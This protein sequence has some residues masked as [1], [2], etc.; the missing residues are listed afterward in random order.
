MRKAS[1][2]AVS[3]ASESQEERQ[4]SATIAI[5]AS[6]IRQIFQPRTSKSSHLW[7]LAQK[8]HALAVTV[9]EGWEGLPP[10][11]REL[12]TTFACAVIDPPKG[13]KGFFRTFINRF[14]SA[15]VLAWIVL[16]GEQDAFIAYATAFQRLVNAIL[17]AIEREGTGYQKALSEALEGAF[18]DWE[19]SEAMTAEEACE[20]LRQISD[21]A[22]REL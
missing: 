6:E 10:E 18:G 4:V 16:K 22:L 19:S 7:E 21:Q 3:E 9:E 14:Y 15:F 11:R 8:A 2:Q 12:L 5:S 17:G 13:I 20:R 1:T